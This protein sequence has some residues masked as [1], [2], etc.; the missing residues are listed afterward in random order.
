VASTAR[1]LLDRYL[2][3]TPRGLCIDQFDDQGRPAA[4]IVPGSLLYHCVLAFSET[5]R[6]EPKLKTVR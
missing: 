5:L 6:L 4:Q 2:A 1:L 3:V